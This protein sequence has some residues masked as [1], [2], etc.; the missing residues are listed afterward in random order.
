MRWIDFDAVSMHA[1]GYNDSWTPSVRLIDFEARSV[2]ALDYND[3]WTSLVRWIGFSRAPKDHR[4]TQGS[5]KPWFRVS[6]LVGPW[7]QNIRSLCLC[8]HLLRNAFLF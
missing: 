5:Y 6:P 2:H 7:N 8:C 4:K 1:L 3:T